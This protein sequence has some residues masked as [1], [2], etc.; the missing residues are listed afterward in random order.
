[1]RGDGA[2]DA[3]DLPLIDCEIFVDGLCGEKTT[4][5]TSTLGQSLQPLLH[6]RI[7]AHR[8]GRGLHEGPYVSAC[9]QYHTDVRET[10]PRPHRPPEKSRGSYGIGRNRPILSAIGAMVP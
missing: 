3:D 10:Q 5:A 8:K 4:T 6:A 9:V 2:L 7:N 1:E